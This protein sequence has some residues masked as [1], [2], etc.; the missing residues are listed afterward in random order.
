MRDVSLSD[1]VRGREWLNELDALDGH[2]R[3]DIPLNATSKIRIF[4]R[5]A[6]PS[7]FIALRTSA[8][9]KDV[10]RVEVVLP[11]HHLDVLERARVCYARNGDGHGVGL[12]VSRSQTAIPRIK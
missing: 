3:F 7:G 12:F 2:K 1:C 10:V 4:A 11:Y 5:G 8:A 6:L 9:V